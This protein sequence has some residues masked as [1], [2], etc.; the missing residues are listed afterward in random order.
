MG[1]AA[2]DAV[3]LLQAMLND[4]Q[5]GLPQAASEALNKI[6]KSP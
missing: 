2:K 6:T 4:R 1:P 5:S 3:P